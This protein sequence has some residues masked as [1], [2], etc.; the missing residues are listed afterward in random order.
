[1]SKLIY[2]QLA[3]HK[4]FNK[5]VKFGLKRIKLALCLLGNPE[6]KLKNV[7]DKLQVSEEMGLIIRTAGSKTTAGEIKK[8]Y[9]FLTKS[10]NKVRE[11]TLSA[12]A[13]SLIFENGSVIHRTLR[14]MYDD[15][16]K[17]II[18]ELI[19]S[20][21]SKK[22]HCAVP[23]SKIEDTIRKNNKSVKKSSYRSPALPS[24]AIA[25]DNI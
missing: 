11:D 5:S 2:H 22:Y 19:S 23:A 12:N 18:I 16:T 15:N 7:I 1:M 10:W 14:D 13:P 9:K 3:N 21:N 20:M 4:L 24:L 8:D 17:N 25:V 6:K